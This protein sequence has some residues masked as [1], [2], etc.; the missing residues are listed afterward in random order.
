MISVQDVSI[1][2]RGRTLF[3]DV[4]VSFR[5]GARYGLTGPNGAGK[6]TF[7]R[8]VMGMQE[9]DSGQ[10]QRPKKVGI[11]PQNHHAFDDRMVIHTVMMG[12]EPLWAAMEER[13]KLW[14]KGDDLTDEEGMRLGELECT[15]ADEDGYTPS[16]TRRRS[17]R[18]SASRR[19]S[20]GSRSA[21]RA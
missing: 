21:T 17:S 13:E 3:K 20:T 9:P 8:I 4:S 11:I 10:V 12:N 1:A 6:T 5:T 15:V 7:L 19:S 18:A 14:E 2:F 16:P